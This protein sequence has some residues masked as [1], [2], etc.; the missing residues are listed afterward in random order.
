MGKSSVA[1]RVSIMATAY[2]RVDYRTV[3]PV[4]RPRLRMV[5]PK[6]AEAVKESVQAP[7]V[8]PV[9]PPVEIVAATAPTDD[10][11]PAPPSWMVAP[12]I[13]VDP[14]L[15]TRESWTASRP[16][17]ATQMLPEQGPYQS[18]RQVPRA[19]L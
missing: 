11:R 13:Q 3:E 10:R 12:P 14:V 6:A 1:I 18:V 9:P 17:A 4:R 5:E 15:D 16:T 2:N 8:A 7:P 19:G